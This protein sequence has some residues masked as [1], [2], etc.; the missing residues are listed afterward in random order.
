MEAWIGKIG[1]EMNP[2]DGSFVGSAAKRPYYDEILTLLK[3]FEDARVKMYQ[4][5][6]YMNQAVVGT[7]IIQNGPSAIGTEIMK[8]K[9]RSA[10]IAFVLSFVSL[11]LSFFT[12]YSAI[13]Y[14]VVYTLAIKDGLKSEKKGLA[15]V[16]IVINSVSILICIFV[17]FLLI[18][19]S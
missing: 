4:G 13:V 19:F 5:Q 14:I 10:I 18:L 16:A 2:G 15:I 12:A 6:P 8:N 7:T 11:V 9:N 17:F 3:V 1:R